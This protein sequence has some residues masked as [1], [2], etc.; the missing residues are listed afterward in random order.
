MHAVR[1]AS[2]WYRFGHVDGMAVLVLQLNLLNNTIL[3]HQHAQPVVFLFSL[4]RLPAAELV[5]TELP[6]KDLS[7]TSA[8]H[9]RVGLGA[10]FCRTRN[11][12]RGGRGG[13]RSIK[14][15]KRPAKSRTR[16]FR[17]FEDAKNW[18]QR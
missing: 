9:K 15:L 7:R 4:L 3:E 12:H 13:G 17:I 2:P 16:T 18:A 11:K 6:L 5:G 1:E 14:D 10:D 8:R